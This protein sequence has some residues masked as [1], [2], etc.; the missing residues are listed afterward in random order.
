MT[1]LVAPNP[2]IFTGPGTNTYLVG[3]SSLIVVDPG[4]DIPNHLD[5][6]VDLGAGRIRQ[7]VVTHTHPDHAPGARGLAART[8][9][10]VV[11]FGPSDGFVPDRVVLDGDLV[12]P[13]EF[14]LKAIHTPGHASNHL[15]WLLE[16]EGLLFAGDHVM[17]G[18]TVVIN[19][20]DGDMSA[21]MTSLELV[22]NLDPSLRAIAPGHGALIGNPG[23]L[24]DWYLAHRYEREARVLDALSTAGSSSA[25]AL[26]PAV[27]A[28]VD[29]SLHEAARLSLWAHLIKLQREGRASSTSA[30]DPEGIWEAL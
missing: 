11:G 27:Y 3:R 4:P 20:P 29:E 24:L 18:S 22:R 28:D 17:E 23:M 30:G 12:I 7:I 5:A 16:S 2:G 25:A 6:I 10:E 15:C 19:P 21:Y 1:R 26:V 13:G 9:A 14:A 8:G